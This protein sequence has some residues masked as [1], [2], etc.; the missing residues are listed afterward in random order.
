MLLVVLRKLPPQDPGPTTHDPVQVRGGDK[1]HKRHF[2]SP[3]YFS[4]LQTFFFF[5]KV[6]GIKPKALYMLNMGC[7]PSDSLSPL[8]FSQG[9]AVTQ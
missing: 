3:S 5:F 1:C 6:L 8:Q 7:I 2:R 4:H 9:L